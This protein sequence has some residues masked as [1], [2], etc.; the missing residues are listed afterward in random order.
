MCSVAQSYSLG[1]ADITVMQAEMSIPAETNTI[2]Y[3][4]KT[5]LTSLSM[6]ENGWYAWTNGTFNLASTHG[7]RQYAN[8]ANFCDGPD[9]VWTS[10]KTGRKFY[11]RQKKK[12]KSTGYQLMN[13]IMAQGWADLETLFEGAYNCTASVSYAPRAVMNLYRSWRFQLSYKP[14]SPPLF[15]ETS[16]ARRCAND[17]CPIG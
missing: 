2:A 8:N 12:R 17:F 13:D 1:T 5:Y 16:Q 9:T 10:P 14:L 11:I 6:K 15:R 4:L 7:C 3:A